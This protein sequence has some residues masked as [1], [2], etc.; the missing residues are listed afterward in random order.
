MRKLNPVS[1]DVTKNFTTSG[2]KEIGDYLY[3][4]L[5][6][7]GN[8]QTLIKRVKTDNSEIKFVLRTTQ[9]IADFWTDPTVHTYNYINKI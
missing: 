8:G 9:T 2:V 4:L 3:A 6:N 7:A 1:V 5:I